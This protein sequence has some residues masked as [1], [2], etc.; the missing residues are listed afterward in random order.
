MEKPVNQMSHDLIARLRERAGFAREENNATAMN[1]AWHFETA[2]NALETLTARIAELEAERAW[3]PIETAPRD[4]GE[5][6]T[7][8]R[9]S[10]HLP[11]D[12]G[13]DI[14]MVDGPGGEGWLPFTILWQPFPAPPSKGTGDGG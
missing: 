5:V 9:I 13:T 2:A 7:C 3:R 10:P 11:L 12:I 8:R 14:Y 6:I 1:D 4:G